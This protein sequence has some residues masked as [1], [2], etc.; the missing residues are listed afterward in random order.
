M[1]KFMKKFI[2]RI[3]LI[4]LI[5]LGVAAA[6]PHLVAGPMAVQGLV[7]Q[8]TSTWPPI[9]V[10]PYA[11]TATNWL[12][13]DYNG[14]I[15]NV[16]TNNG[17]GTLTSVVIGSGGGAG[18]YDPSGS[19]QGA[20]NGLA[21]YNN[22][23]FAVTNNNAAAVSLSGSFNGSLITPWGTGVLEN[24]N[25]SVLSEIDFTNGGQLTVASHGAPVIYFSGALD[26]TG[27]GLLSYYQGNAIGITNIGGSGATM[28]GGPDP[29]L[30]NT[31]GAALTNFV[32]Q[33][34]TAIM[35]GNAQSIT[36]DSVLNKLNIAGASIGG[37][38]QNGVKLSG[39]GIPIVN[40]YY[41][42][43]AAIAGFTNANGS[44]IIY[45]ALDSNSH[46]YTNGINTGFLLPGQ[47]YGNALNT[48]VQ[49]ADNA[50]VTT[51]TPPVSS[52]YVGLDA[53]G[54][55]FTNLAAATATAAGLATNSTIWGGLTNIFTLFSTGNSNI[56]FSSGAT[57][58][59][60]NGFWY[61]NANMIW[62]FSGDSETQING[63]YT[64]S[65]GCLIARDLDDD[66]DAFGDS[67]IIC[68]NSPYLSADLT[69]DAS[70]VWWSATPGPTNAAIHWGGNGNVNGNG[71]V[72]G[73]GATA[74]LV[75]FGTNT[76]TSYVIPATL[77]GD[78]NL[79]G[80]SNVFYSA[81]VAS[82]DT[83]SPSAKENM[84]LGTGPN[85]T[86]NWSLLFGQQP[87]YITPNLLATNEGDGP[88]NHEAAITEQNGALYMVYCANSE[89]QF[90]PQQKEGAALDIVY[91]DDLHN[92]R[93]IAQ[94]QPNGLTNSTVTGI[95]NESIGNPGW[96]HVNWGGTNWIIYSYMT[97]SGIALDP[98][99]IIYALPMT[100]GA[101][102][103]N[104]V[105]GNPV[106]I[107]VTTNMCGAGLIGTIL[108]NNA[109][110]YILPG[111]QGTGVPVYCSANFLGP[112]VAET[113]WDLPL[114][115]SSSMLVLSTPNNLYKQEWFVY[116]GNGYGT[117]EWSTNYGTN[118]GQSVSSFQTLN[119]FIKSGQWV[120]YNEPFILTGPLTNDSTDVQAADGYFSGVISAP[121]VDAGNI[122]A[123]SISADDLI[124]SGVVAGNYNQP[125][126]V[127]DSFNCGSLVTNTGVYCQAGGVGVIAGPDAFGSFFFGA[128]YYSDDGQ[129]GPVWEFED[130]GQHV[131]SP[132][133]N[134]AGGGFYVN[135]GTILFAQS[136][137][138]SR[139]GF[140]SMAAGH[141]AFSTTGITNTSGANLRVFAF[142]GTAVNF[143]NY[144]VHWGNALGN[145]TSPQNYDLQTNEA[146][147]GTSCAE[148]TNGNF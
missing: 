129:D 45:Q 20:T 38:S 78:L 99:G 64:N 1:K 82:S 87:S 110:L 74:P 122:K 17:A 28:V 138:Q 18:S 115:S 91:S 125:F 96:S 142:T 130:G 137:V 48:Y 126:Y 36:P 58:G 65:A 44:A 92:W 83:Y 101:T 53:T 77:G 50:T 22:F 51:L 39:S 69:I 4:G 100:F 112:Y 104:V 133:L 23:K 106:A 145:V 10:P 76:F 108:T 127:R 89:G 24:S 25:P 146:L 79:I 136:P 68:S 67:Y 111:C 6:T 147:I 5:V 37:I 33:Q 42:T 61:W 70:N 8:T 16:C 84:Y 60:L 59:F 81:L 15:F 2:G 88:G 13:V 114:P 139:Q 21:G 117:M 131:N 9:G 46:V 134:I 128:G 71:G 73:R 62:I 31:G 107:T 75:V 121:S 49:W 43:N 105:F 55:Q 119:P 34:A 86:N 95:T 143:T 54:V 35:D 41:V 11:G 80:A 3:G 123:T 113:A 30:S 72:P 27:N 40:V 85:P 116:G 52:W 93:Q 32:Q 63:G 103:T 132:M 109:G 98:G 102:R 118:W 140:N 120:L 29:I 14:T 12:Q 66:D 56:L 57:L 97:N 135:A 124:V 94:W 47:A 144:T 141:V 26:L 7:I 19:S 90:G 148:S